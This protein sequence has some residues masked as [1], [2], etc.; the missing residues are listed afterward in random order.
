MQAENKIKKV[1]IKLDNVLLL[2]YHAQEN[3]QNLLSL[4]YDRNG[5]L[6]LGELLRLENIL[7]EDGLIQYTVSEKGLEIELTSEGRNFLYHGGYGSEPSAM[8]YPKAMRVRNENH[9][10]F[11]ILM[12]GIFIIMLLRFIVFHK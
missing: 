10:R 11:N 9:F 12:A 3:K 5:F 6:F 7:F 1:E 2:V 4:F 8:L